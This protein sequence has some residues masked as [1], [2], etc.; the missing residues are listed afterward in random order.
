M[1]SIKY[2]DDETEEYKIIPKEEFINDVSWNLPFEFVKQQ[3]DENEDIRMPL[4]HQL[5]RRA[6][7]NPYIETIKTSNYY[8]QLLNEIINGNKIIEKIELSLYYENDLIEPLFG[9]M[10]NIVEKII[11]YDGKDEFYSSLASTLVYIS[12]FDIDEETRERIIEGIS[13]L[14][15]KDFEDKIDFEKELMMPSLT[16]EELLE[17]KERNKQSFIE[18]VK[19]KKIK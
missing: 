6:K 2:Y 13:I 11:N 17:I 3:A 1:E 12:K 9:G 16:K 15:D 7:V 18:Q 19:G 4:Y 14:I 5:F 10:R 8:E